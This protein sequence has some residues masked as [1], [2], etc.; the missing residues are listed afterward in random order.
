MAKPKF[1]QHETAENGQTEISSA[2]NCR[3]WPN[4]NLVS[5][6]LPKVAKT[7][8]SSARNCRKWPNRNFV[9]TKLPKIA[10]PKFRKKQNCRKWPN[11]NFLSTKLPKVAKLEFRQHKIAKSGQTE[12]SVWATFVSFVI[13][14]QLF[15]P[16]S[17]L[18]AHIC[19]TYERI[20]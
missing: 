5:T 4:R 12:I 6:K 15:L 11:R 18:C 2:R 19:F 1:R 14:L 8:I 7:E 13:T 16:Q 10:K 17:Q 9:S 3:K 20:A